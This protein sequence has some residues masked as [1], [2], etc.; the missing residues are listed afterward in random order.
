MS[1]GVTYSVFASA[2]PFNIGAIE[3]LVCG[4]AGAIECIERGRGNG[5]KQ[6][7]KW[8]LIRKP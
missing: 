5:Q 7:E 1:I 6:N 2:K 3:G 8:R 4:I